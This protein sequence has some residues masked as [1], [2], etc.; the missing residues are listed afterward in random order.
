[1]AVGICLWSGTPNCNQTNG[2]DSSDLTI[3]H[4]RLVRSWGLRYWT[5]GRVGKREA[6]EPVRRE[7]S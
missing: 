3:T 2:I 5:I 6:R 1:M 4:A 7:S